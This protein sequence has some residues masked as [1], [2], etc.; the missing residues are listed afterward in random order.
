MSVGRA[1]GQNCIK[2]YAVQSFKEMTVLLCYGQR[3]D[4]VAEKERL[5]IRDSW[6]RFALR[7]TSFWCWK[8][9]DANQSIR[10]NWRW[11]CLYL[12]RNQG[13]AAIVDE[14]AAE[15]EKRSFLRRCKG[16]GEGSL[17]PLS[18]GKSAMGTGQPHRNFWLKTYQVVLRSPPKKEPIMTIMILMKVG[19]S[20]LQ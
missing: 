12:V 17:L 15:G 16:A 4:F 7:F 9:I 10:A 2:V 6:A 11:I 1:G 13:D 20:L 5:W 18:T 8:T 3:T 19:S 14:R